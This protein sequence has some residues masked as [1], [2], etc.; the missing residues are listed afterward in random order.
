MFQ[1]CSG[2]TRSVREAFVCVGVG[3]WVGGWVGVCVCV[4]AC[5]G[6]QTNNFMCLKHI[7]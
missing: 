1:K 5:T 2:K 6:L 3:G 7:L 4:R